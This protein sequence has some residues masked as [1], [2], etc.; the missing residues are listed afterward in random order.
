[1]HAARNFPQFPFHRDGSGCT[2]FPSLTA[3]VTASLCIP[4]VPKATST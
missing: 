4:A 2:A 3:T 1:M